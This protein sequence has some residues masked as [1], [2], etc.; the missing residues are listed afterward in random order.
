MLILGAAGYA[1]IQFGE[2]YLRYY[3]FRD[4][5]TQDVHFADRLS[6]DDIRK[7]LRAF[8]DSIGLP[9]DAR[10]IG[11]RRHP[12]S[13]TVWSEYEETVDLKVLHR[14]IPFTITVEGDL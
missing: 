9:D 11:I 14:V 10:R 4:A 6:D 1:G 12:H 2:V 5:M 13:I 3:Q 8:A 7:H